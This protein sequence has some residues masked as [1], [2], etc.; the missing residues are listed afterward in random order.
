ML[1]AEMPLLYTL[2]QFG[3]AYALID[4]FIQSFYSAF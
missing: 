1:I 2:L 4:L 3:V